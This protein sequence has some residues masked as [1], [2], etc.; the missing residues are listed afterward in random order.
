MAAVDPL[1]SEPKSRHVKSW[2][3]CSTMKDL[4]WYRGMD[5]GLQ[6]KCVFTLVKRLSILTA[7]YIFGASVIYTSKQGEEAS[8]VNHSHQ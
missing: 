5:F 7:V 8:R 4:S 3:I 1:L 2:R 6:S